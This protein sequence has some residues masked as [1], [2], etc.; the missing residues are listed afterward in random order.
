M[1]LLRI[2]VKAH[3]LVLLW[4]HHTNWK[5]PLCR[6][7]QKYLLMLNRVIK[8]KK[9]ISFLIVAKQMYVVTPQVQW[10]LPRKFDK[11]S[12]QAA[13]PSFLAMTSLMCH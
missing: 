9:V 6:K 12:F 3:L 10:F 5:R 7:I 1:F 11:Q 2:S 13:V 4:R 8:K